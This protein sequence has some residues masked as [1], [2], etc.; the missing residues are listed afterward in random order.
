MAS[1]A[2]TETFAPGV[3]FDPDEKQLV[4]HYLIGKLSGNT[5]EAGFSYIREID[6][7]QHQPSQIP[8]ELLQN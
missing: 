1:P 3:V 6:L 8:S 5:G 7:Y 2:A 4:F